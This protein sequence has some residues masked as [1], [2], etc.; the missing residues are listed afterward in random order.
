MNSINFRPKDTLV[1]LQEHDN[2]ESLTPALHNLCSHF[3]QV[4]KLVVLTA[5]HEGAQQ[6]I[7]FLRLESMHQEQILMRELGV[8]KFGEEIVI[9]VDLKPN[10]PVHE[11]QPHTQWRHVS[12]ANSIALHG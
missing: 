2:A 8:G 3:G 1:E 7:C 10:K 11:S 4:E 5:R 9:V 6:A 12:Q